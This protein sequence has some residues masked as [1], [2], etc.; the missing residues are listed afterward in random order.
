MIR[1]PWGIYGRQA[2]VRKN[3]ARTLVFTKSSNV[4][5]FVSGVVSVFAWPALCTVYPLSASSFSTNS[6]WGV[7]LV[8]MTLH[9]KDVNIISS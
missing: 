5:I 7:I 8:E 1:P 6:E 2:C 3:G 4:S 9:T